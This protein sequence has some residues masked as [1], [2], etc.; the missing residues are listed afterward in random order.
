MGWR[1]F[2]CELAP[3][4][5][6]I[7]KRNFVDWQ[8]SFFEHNLTTVQLDN[9]SQNSQQ[10]KPLSHPFDINNSTMGQSDLEVLIEMGFEKARAEIAVKKTGGRTSPLLPLYY[11]ANTTL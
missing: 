9:F 5:P 3:L 6:L 10:T 7:I 1:R 8:P 4:P 2:G 11:K